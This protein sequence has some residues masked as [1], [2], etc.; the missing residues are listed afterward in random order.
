MGK[1]ILIASVNFEPSTGKLGI[2]HDS[3]IP[4]HIPED[5][6]RFKN[7]T[8]NNTV[9]MGRKTFDSIGKPL[10]NRRN[11]VLSRKFKDIKNVEVIDDIEQLE[12]NSD[13]DIYIIGGYNV[14]SMFIKNCDLVYL[15][16]VYG[17]F[18][19]NCYFPDILDNMMLIDAS[20][21]MFSSNSNIEYQ[22]LTYKNSNGV[23]NDTIYL[24]LANSI[25]KN[26]VTRT[27]R[28]GTG[29]VSTF[30]NQ[31]TFDISN[32]FPLLTTKFVSWK[33]VIHELLWILRGETK[34][35]YLEQNNVKIWRKNTSREFLD[36]IGKQE[37]DEGDL[38]FG[39]GHQLRHFGSSINGKG[40]F[41]QLLYVEN[42]LK[43]DPFSRRILWN[44][45]NPSDLDKM[46]LQPCHNQIQFYVEEE[47]KVK[48]LSGK[49]NLRSNDIFL[50][51]PY[52]IASYSC[53]IYILAL[54]C[55]MKPKK[56][57][58]SIGDSHIYSNHITQITQQLNRSPRAQPWLI[59]NEKIKDK[60]YSKI[61][62]SDFDVVGYFPHTSIKAEMA[63]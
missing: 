17:T 38:L 55:D 4:W 53:L 18:N 14:Y 21:K 48:Y 46:V 29:T 34:T 1:I 63:I 39:Y 44:L 23:S 36:S 57:I 41:D 47:N 49:L 60:D 16:V 27:D 19:C 12:L 13:S 2:G 51:N 58:V 33:N 6:K 15:T 10:D 11:I 32:S 24:N 3:N 42:L 8:T 28:T 62:I 35:D 22:Y 56:L 30:G 5:L 61:T 26:G 31:V 20:E 54:K 59:L 52:N 43:T 7:L 45:W 50:G 37:Y 40:G 9:V 25:L